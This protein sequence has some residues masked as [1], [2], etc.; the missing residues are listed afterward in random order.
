MALGCGP[1]VDAQ[2]AP[3]PA[4]LIASRAA[5]PGEG[6]VCAWALVV[7]SAEVGR[8]C[9]PGENPGFQAELERSEA[10]L[11]AFVRANGKNT[12]PQSIAQ[13]KATQGHVGRP[14]EQ[15]CFADAII[16]Y[17][18]FEKAGV[19]KLREMVDKGVARPGE[20]TWGSCL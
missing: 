4:P 18:S 11:D 1:A 10:K 6:L 14:K 15:V 20:P 13:F 8:R 17:R 12:T 19:E 5:P 2:P 3:S 16:I 7:N 9:F